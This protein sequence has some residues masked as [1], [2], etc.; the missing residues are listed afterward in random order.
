MYLYSYLQ[1]VLTNLSEIRHRR[2]RRIAIEN[3]WVSWNS[4]KWKPHTLLN[5]VNNIGSNFLFIWLEKKIG[6]DTN[7][8][9]L[10]DGEFRE[11]PRNKSHT[12]LRGLNKFLLALFTFILWLGWNPVPEI[13]I[14]IRLL[15]MWKFRENW[16]RE[17]R[18]SSYGC[19]FTCMYAR[20]VKLCDIWKIKK[21]HDRSMYYVT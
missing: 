6:T 8:N 11:N 9:V 5:D 7:K 19:K 2:S 1:H 15:S 17:G 12:F 13:H 20:T 10:S 3:M 18:K 16:R 21:R 4:L 14:I